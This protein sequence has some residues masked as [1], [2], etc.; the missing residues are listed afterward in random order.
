M[1]NNKV[2]LII[3]ILIVVLFF[4]FLVVLIFIFDNCFWIK[5]EFVCMQNSKGEGYCEYVG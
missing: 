3:V 5:L 4:L 1:R 2:K